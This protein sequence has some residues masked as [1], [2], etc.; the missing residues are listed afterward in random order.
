MRTGEAQSQMGRNC[1]FDKPNQRIE[2]QDASGHKDRAAFAAPRSEL[3]WWRSLGLN[4][5]NGFS[6]FSNLRRLLGGRKAWASALR[7]QGFHFPY[8]P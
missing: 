6:G 7:K 5:L 8:L 1:F 2:K 4:D 3:L